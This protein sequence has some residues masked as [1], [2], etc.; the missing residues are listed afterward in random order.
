MSEHP[1]FMSSRV[2]FDLGGF[3]GWA[4]RP[5]FYVDLGARTEEFRALVTG[6]VRDAQDR[7]KIAGDRVEALAEI[8]GHI[9][10]VTVPVRALRR[11]LG[12]QT[13]MP[14]QL[15]GRMIFASVGWDESRT[16]GLR[17]WGQMRDG[18]FEP[19]PEGDPW[20]RPN[21]ANTGLVCMGEEA[22]GQLQN[23]VKASWSRVRFAF[24]LSDDRCDYRRDDDL[25]HEHCTALWEPQYAL[26][27][28]QGLRGAEQLVNRGLLEP[29]GLSNKRAVT[30]F[31]VET[32]ISRSDLRPQLQR[33]CAHCL[34]R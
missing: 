14:T 13:G 23:P 17:E 1:V 11:D 8:L 10:L 2:H 19:W 34:D 5:T 18:M 6:N 26:R 21:K 9:V 16:Q 31:D 22:P 24:S 7:Q 3:D 28:H 30:P 15:D 27:V 32:F 25:V 33:A 29:R 20:Y 12:P 4:Y